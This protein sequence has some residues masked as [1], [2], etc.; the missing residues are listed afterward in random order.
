MS[1][2]ATQLQENKHIALKMLF[3]TLDRFRVS[4]TAHLDFENMASV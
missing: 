4:W 3:S 1:R 2:A